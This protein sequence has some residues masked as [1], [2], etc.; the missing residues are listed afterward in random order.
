MPKK[1]IRDLAGKPLLSHTIEQA[2]QVP[3]FDLVVLS[4]DNDEI[5]AVGAEQGI[6]I[7]DRPSSLA[8]AEAKTETALLHAIDEL[9]P[10]SRFDYVVVL[11]PTSPF[12]QPETISKCIRSIIDEQA[13]SLVTVKETRASLG[14]LV[15]GKFVLLNPDAPRRRQDREPFYYESSTLYVCSINHLIR[16]ESLVSDDWL[17]V[18]VSE[19][20]AFDINTLFDFHVAEALFAMEE[21]RK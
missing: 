2:H 10:D 1:N 6:R 13:T 4:T 21:A 5:A 11:E 9:S 17:G 19:N 15:D 18:E 20:E 3:E 16:E 12:R 14:R 7:I 8:T